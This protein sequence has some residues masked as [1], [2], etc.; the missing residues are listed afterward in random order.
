VPREFLDQMFFWNGLDLQ[1]KPE[2]FAVYYNQ[3]RVHAALGGGT[4]ESAAART[5]PDAPTCVT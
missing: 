5:H 4:P 1:R 2:R 3:R